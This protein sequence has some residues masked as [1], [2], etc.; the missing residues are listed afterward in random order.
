VDRAESIG[1]GAAAIGHVALFTL[2]SFTLLTRDEVPR[3]E[4]VMVTLTD[5]IGPMATA[6]DR[7]APADERRDIE[8]DVDVTDPPETEPLPQPGVTPTPAPPRPAERR[9]EQP[10]EPRAERHPPREQRRSS[11]I[12]GIT[13]GI[14]MTDDSGTSRSQ[15]PVSEA[16]RSNLISRIVNALRPCYNLGSLQGTAAEDIVVRMR[17]QP[18]RDRS[19]NRSQL[20]VVSVH[21]INGANRQYGSQMVEAARSA[22]LDPRCPLPPLPDTLYEN[23]W[24]DVIIRFIPA[25]LT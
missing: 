13:E 16:D 23:G 5:D 14:G 11:R 4:A 3:R 10:P 2:L 1:F 15:A 18:S 9:N 21:G 19:V 22:I 7:P 20:G 6:A 17:I 8:K 12:A 25:Q 24:S